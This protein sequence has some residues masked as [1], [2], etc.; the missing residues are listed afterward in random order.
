MNEQALIEFTSH[1]A[2]RNADVAIYPDR[3]E[4]GAHGF[5]GDAGDGRAP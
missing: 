5:G 2:G 4:V 1:V 3:I